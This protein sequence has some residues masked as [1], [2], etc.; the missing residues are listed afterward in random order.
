MFFL[1]FG[2]GMRAALPCQIF[3]KCPSEQRELGLLKGLDDSKMEGWKDGPRDW[4]MMGRLKWEENGYG[5]LLSVGS[6][7]TSPPL[8]FHPLFASFL[9]LPFLWSYSSSAY[10]TLF[11]IQFPQLLFI[12]VQYF[13]QLDVVLK[14]FRNECGMVRCN[15]SISFSTF[16]ICVPLHIVVD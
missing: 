4:W 2:V 8:F 1:F 12:F 9:V 11:F 16:S 5:Y 3:P 13:S 15:V 6:T 14:C 10:Y 7:F